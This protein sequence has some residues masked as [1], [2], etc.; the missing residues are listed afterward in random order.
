MS[1]AINLKEIREVYNL[2]QEE[3]ALSLGITRELVNKME[4]G[5]SS[6]SKATKLLIQNFL[7]DKSE[8]TSHEMTFLGGTSH[9]KEKKA[10]N[11]PYFLERREQ[12]KMQTPVLIPLVGIKAQ[13]GYIN[14]YEHADYMD[15][16]EKYSLPPGINPAGA[17][18]SYFEVDGDSMEPTVFAGDF[19][20]ASMLPHEDWKDIKNF[21]VYII[22]TKDQLLIKRVFQKS[23]KEWILISDN[24]TLYAQVP[25]LLD[26]IKQVWTFRRQIRSRVP[27]PKEFR[28]TA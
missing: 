27:Q 26:E 5:K 17:V 22:L 11:Q 10:G 4:K 19:I 18:W 8:Y 6:I 9:L 12:K 16:L 14:G 20:L 1:S 13:A 21:G 2:T 24:D 7:S 3:F 28:I 25:L 23:E 15:T